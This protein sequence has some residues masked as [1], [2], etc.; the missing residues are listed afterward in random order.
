MNKNINCLKIN[1]FYLKFLNHNK[2]LTRNSSKQSACYR[3]KYI[4]YVKTY[5]SFCNFFLAFFLFSI[6]SIPSKTLNIKLNKI[7]FLFFYF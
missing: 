3:I 4:L 2:N 6:H 7:F 5:N 1:S